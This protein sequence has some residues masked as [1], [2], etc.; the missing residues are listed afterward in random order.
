MSDEIRVQI[1][2]SADKGSLSIAKSYSDDVDLAAAAPNMAGGTQAIGFA[3]HEAIALGDVATNGWAFFRNLDATNFVEIGLDVGATFYPLVRLNAG[4]AAVL[5]LAQGVAP[6][7][8]ADTG[9][10]VLEKWI[11]DN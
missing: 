6:Y 4:E 11:L 5:R 10:V 3:A 2:F 1:A 7:A 8:Q 9:A